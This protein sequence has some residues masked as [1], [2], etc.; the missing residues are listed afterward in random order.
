MHTHTHTHTR[1]HKKKMTTY[2]HTKKK[3]KEV[4]KKKKLFAIKTMSDNV[5]VPFFVLH[6]TLLQKDRQ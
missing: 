5:V 1:T 4:K 6:F 3:T 2:K